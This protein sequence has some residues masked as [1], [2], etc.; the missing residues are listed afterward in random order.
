MLVRK[1]PR[2]AIVGH[3]LV[4]LN[5]VCSVPNVQVSLFRK[6]GATWQDKIAV[7]LAS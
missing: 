3:S 1:M 6:P 7:N 4:P 2:V 5:F